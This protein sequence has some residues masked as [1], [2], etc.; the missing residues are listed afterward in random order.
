MQ[1]ISTTSSTRTAD[2]AH[3]YTPGPASSWDSMRRLAQAVADTINGTEGAPASYWDAPPAVETPGRAAAAELGQGREVEV[4]ALSDDEC[5]A[6]G[7]PLGTLEPCITVQPLV[8]AQASRFDAL[9]DGAGCFHLR[10]FGMAAEVHH[11]A[12]GT[13]PRGLVQA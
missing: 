12:R 8:G 9:D 2:L 11:V 5:E 1:A 13:G 3:T 4:Y 6:A 10:A 7:L